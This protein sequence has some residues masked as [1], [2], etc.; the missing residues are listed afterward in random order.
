VCIYIYIYIYI[1][2]Y[3]IYSSY[4][5]CKHNLHR[6]IN[7]YIYKLHICVC[8]YIYIYIYIHTHIYAVFIVLCILCLHNLYDK[9]MIPKRQKSRTIEL[10]YQT[11]CLEFIPVQIMGIRSSLN[12]Q[13]A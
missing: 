10:T 7:I 9:Y 4:R 6:P 8:I 3:V 13:F 2:S 11:R 5:L 12:C 1:V